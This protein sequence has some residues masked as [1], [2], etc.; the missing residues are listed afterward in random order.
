MARL[1]FAAPD[2][3][4]DPVRTS[5]CLAESIGDA[6][7]A[8]NVREFVDGWIAENLQAVSYEPVDDAQ[9]AQLRALQ[10]FT[11]ASRAGIKRAAIESE[12]GSLVSYMDAAIER[13]NTEAFRNANRT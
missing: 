10:C 11:A 13:I 4:G 3:Y 8:A 7:M 12:C 5:I 2:D 9:E 1:Q 6:P